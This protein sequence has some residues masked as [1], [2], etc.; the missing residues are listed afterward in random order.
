MNC[1]KITERRLLLMS[2]RFSYLT[3]CCALNGLILGEFAKEWLKL[4]LESIL[5]NVI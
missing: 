1:R 3:L 5:E 4:T 2:D